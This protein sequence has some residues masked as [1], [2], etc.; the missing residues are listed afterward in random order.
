MPRAERCTAPPDL[1][2]TPDRT[3]V[4]AGG[5][6]IKKTVTALVFGIYG[7]GVTPPECNV[8]VENLGDYLKEQG[9]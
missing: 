1:L 8:V 2:P 5:V 3:P 4:G 9:I 7:E 6:T